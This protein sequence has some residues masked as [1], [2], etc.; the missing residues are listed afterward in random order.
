MPPPAHA[1]GH[2][3]ERQVDELLVPIRQALLGSENPAQLQHRLLV[4]LKNYEHY[5]DSYAR[6]AEADRQAMLRHEKPFMERAIQ[7]L[8]RNYSNSEFGVGEFCQA[9]G[10]SR[11]SAGN[12]LRAEAGLSVGQFIR[13]YRL[14]IACKLLRQNRGQRN[15]NEI[16][17]NVGFNDPKY[18]TRCFTRAYGLSPSAF[19]EREGS[20]NSARL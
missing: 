18:F 7:Q 14:R 3:R 19:A 20:E 13:S 5:H 1:D 10:M 6:S 11:S 9:V 16:A 4:V 12:R 8:E 2:S 17:F 15:I